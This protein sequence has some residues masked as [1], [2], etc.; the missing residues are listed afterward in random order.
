MSKYRSAFLII[1]VIFTVFGSLNHYSLAAASGQCYPSKPS[2]QFDEIVT[3]I[4]NTPTGIN[5]T[6]I[7][8]YLPNG[9]ITRLTIGKIGVGVRPYPI[10]PAGPLPGRRMVVLMD[11]STVLFTTYYDVAEPSTPP[12]PA[13]TS[14][15]VIRYQTQTVTAS[16]T[17]TRSFTLE[18]TGITTET[19]VSTITV[20]RSP[21]MSLVY[22]SSMVMAVLIA[23]ILILILVRFRKPR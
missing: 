20:D 22:V 4:I 13:T 12:I 10:G 8:V 19:V 11:D 15:T 17:V 23:V 14:Q 1:V 2:Y 7:L 18:R 9:Q 5:N 16:T 21:P 6:R 3:L